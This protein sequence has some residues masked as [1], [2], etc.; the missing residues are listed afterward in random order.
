VPRNRKAPAAATAGA[1][2]VIT[3]AKNC[4]AP[5]WRVQLLAARYGLAMGHAATVAALA[6]AGYHG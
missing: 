2:S 4:S 1:S 5:G 3:T 6:L